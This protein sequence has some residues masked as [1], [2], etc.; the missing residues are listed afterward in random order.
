MTTCGCS[1]FAEFSW[2]HV[3][4]DDLS[5]DQRDSVDHILE[6]GKHLLGFINEVLDIARVEAGEMDT[7]LEPVSV[8]M[9]GE[10]S[11]DLVQQLAN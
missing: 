7:S 10:E 11:L 1:S 9:M 2:C 4:M 5:T 3:R 8:A 6:G